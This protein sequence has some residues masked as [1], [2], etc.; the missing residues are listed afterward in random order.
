[1]P[2]CDNGLA[3]FIREY[4]IEFHVLWAIAYNDG[5][6]VWRVPNPFVRLW[7]NPSASR[8]LGGKRC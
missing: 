5:R 3:V 4:G 1:M 6:T 8:H 7:V 2:L